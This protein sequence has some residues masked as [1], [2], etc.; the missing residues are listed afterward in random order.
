VEARI[1]RHQVEA[2][3]FQSNRNPNKQEWSASQGGSLDGD[4]VIL[5]QIRRVLGGALLALIVSSC[6]SVV[7]TPQT[8]TTSTVAPPVEPPQWGV[9]T[10]QLP[11]FFYAS[12]IPQRSRY[13]IEETFQKASQYWPNYGPLE[14]WVTGIQTMPIFNMINDYCDRRSELKQMNKF[15]C[16]D[17]NRNGSFEEYRKWSAIDVMEREHR[18]QGQLTHTAEYG[19]LQIILSNPAGF[20]DEF[21]EYTA[22]DQ[23]IIFH[24]YFHVVQRSASPSTVDIEFNPATRK[25][26]FGPTWFSEGSAEFMSLRAVSDL[27]LRG[28]L[29]IYEGE[30]DD[31]SFHDAMV[32]KLDSAKAS[33][34]RHKNLNLSDA[35][36]RSEKLSPYDIGAWAIAYLVQKTSPNV[37]LD[38]FYP[39]IADLGWAKTF[40]LSFGMSPAEFEKEFMKFMKLTTIEQTPILRSEP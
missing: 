10:N 6:G 22:H 4:E 9:P 14:I 40:K 7:A 15:T 19:F 11:E 30:L 27:R 28:E 36:W 35:D 18:M 39:N 16:L 33:M 8:T 17:K 12:D 24:E 23:Q 21:S 31:F 5:R 13:R 38:T 29:P 26:F 37:L 20:T 3:N 32:G 25:K 2:L 1:R 34:L